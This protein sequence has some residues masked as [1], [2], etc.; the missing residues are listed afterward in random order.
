VAYHVPQGC[1]NRLQIRRKSRRQGAG[2]SRPV[3]CGPAGVKNYEK[4]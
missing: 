4:T 2:T 1:G 3:L